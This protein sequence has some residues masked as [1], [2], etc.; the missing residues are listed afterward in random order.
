MKKTI[1]VQN[2]TIGEGMPK[3]CVSLIGRTRVELIEEASLLK[4]LEVDLVEWRIDFFEE[5]EK[6]EQVKLVLNEIRE[7]LLDKPLIFTFRSKKEGGEREVSN[8]Y[9]L[10]LYEAIIQTKLVD[11]IDIELFKDEHDINNLVE[12]AH[13]K[14]IYVIISNHDF[15]KTP[16]K[17]E[18]ITRLKR[19]QD[20]GADIPKI[21]VMPNSSKDVITLLE[22]TNKMNEKYAKTPIITIS[23]GAKGI[24]SRLSGEVFGSSITFA[25]AKSSSAPGQVSIE[26]LKEVLQLLHQ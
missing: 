21:A 11:F 9:Y 7:I 10:D 5:V 8:T 20:L 23:M 26:K 14:G 6:I 16:L 24:I 25:S 4:T 18:M 15:Q 3:I 19:A 22:A 2:V 13:S 1:T 17:E 12:Q